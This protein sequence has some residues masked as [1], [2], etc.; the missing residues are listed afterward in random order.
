MTALQFHRLRTASTVA[1]KGRQTTMI[2]VRILVASALLAGVSWGVWGLLDDAARRVAAGADRQR[3][4]AA[5]AGVLVYMR[6]VLVMRIPEAHQV[7]GL[8]RGRWLGRRIGASRGRVGRSPPGLRPNID[9][10]LLHTSQDCVFRL[11]G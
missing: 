3:R 5:A 4:A 8:I 11:G 10:R 2:T 9:R 6:A 7:S 1:W